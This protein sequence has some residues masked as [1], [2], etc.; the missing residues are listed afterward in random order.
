MEI[1]TGTSETMDASA[2][3]HLEQH[4]LSLQ[5]AGAVCASAGPAPHRGL[6]IPFAVMSFR[7]YVGSDG[8]ARL[9]ELLLDACL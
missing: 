6:G 1:P 4:F 8:L 7:C 9:E 2:P 5:A 3:L